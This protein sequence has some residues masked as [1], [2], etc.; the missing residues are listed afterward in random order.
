V[1]KTRSSIGVW[2]VLGQTAL[3]RYA[4]FHDLECGGL[5]E[6]LFTNCREG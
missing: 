6:A 4:A 5:G 2:I 3:T 1:A